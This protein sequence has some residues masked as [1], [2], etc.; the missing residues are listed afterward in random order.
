[1]SKRSFSPLP[2]ASTPIRNL[3]EACKKG[4]TIIV[5]HLL[6]EGVD[7]NAQDENG[8]TALMAASEW[9]HLQVVKLLLSRN[10]NVDIQTHF[11]QRTA[12]QMAVSSG[13]MDIVQMLLTKDINVD[14]RDRDGQTALMEAVISDQTDSVR[15]L[16]E[17]GADLLIQDNKGE[18]AKDLAKKLRCTEVENLLTEV[19]R[20]VEILAN[21]QS[22]YFLKS[23]LTVL[24][25]SL[26]PRNR[27]VVQQ[28]LFTSSELNPH[29]P[30]LISQWNHPHPPLNS[31]KTN[32]SLQ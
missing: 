31:S 32:L 1:M 16:L 15:L 18:T 25:N 22:L 11:V 20:I 27:V 14:L 10:A 6:D 28:P 3:L 5:E 23:T 9:D 29:H 8:W 17:K 26:N 21:I 19:R 12:L 4:D 7:V 30:P 13:R 2:P 24:Y